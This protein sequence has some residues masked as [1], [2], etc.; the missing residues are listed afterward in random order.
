MKA[1]RT[2]ICLLAMLLLTSCGGTS[3]PAEATGEA[4]AAVET[5]AEETSPYEPDDLPELDY[6]GADMNVFVQDYGGYC[7]VDFYVE[8]LNGDIVND[9]VHQRNTSVGERLNLNLAFN[10]HTHNWDTHREYLNL[11]RSTVMAGDGAYDLLAGVGYFFPTFLTDGI[12]MPL[13]DMPYIDIEKPWWSKKFMENSAL[14]GQYYM[15]TGDACLGLIKNMFCVFQNVDLYKDLGLEAD[16]YQLVREGKWTLDT[17]Q[18][19]LA[20]SYGDLNGD[21]IR[22]AEDRFGLLV[23]S[24]N[25]ITGFIEPCDIQYVTFEGDAAKFVFENEH[26]FT[27]MDTLSRF[28]WETDGVFFDKNG[29]LETA[30]R[31]IFKNGNIVFATGW[32]MHTDAFRD[33]D[34]QYSV[35]PYPKYDQSQ[36]GYN[37]TVLTTYGVMAIPMDCKDP[38]RTAAVIEAFGSESYRTVTPAYFEIALKVKYSSDNE[39]AQMFDIIRAGIDFDFGYAYTSALGGMSDNYFRGPLSGPNGNWASTAASG[40]AKTQQMLD[41]LVAV[42]R[43]IQ[44]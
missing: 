43:N 9:A 30:D 38:D 14:D 22:D 39:M 4:T 27:V 34:F 28:I 21:G 7:G 32:F 15:V 26:N 6:G 29:E 44:E 42:I 5:V 2:I 19:I 23:N 41:E 33:L 31:S 12:L 13:A 25:H 20:D 11:V 24:V 40:K 10:Q 35:L 8:G 17:M 1:K 18:E 36:A 3:D 37:T 16:P